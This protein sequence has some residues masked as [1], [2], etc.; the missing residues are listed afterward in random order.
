VR[1]L[2]RSSIVVAVLLL[3]ATVLEAQHPQVRKG[4]WIGFGIGYGSAKPTCDSCGP[5]TSEGS[6]TGHIRL[7]GTMSPHVLLGG[8]IDAWTKSES[9]GTLSLGN[10]TAAVYY[11]PTPTSGLFLKG[12]IGGSAFNGDFGGVSADGAGY[13]ITLGAGY[14]LRV[15]TNVSLTPVANLM[16]G[17]VGDI[18][19]SGSVVISGWKQTIFEFGLDVTFH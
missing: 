10:V 19:S 8:D 1:T 18:K 7:G 12:G 5:T 9:G 15:G 14:D 17:N 2:L 3:F 16:W 11:Y 13:G 4:F 6:W